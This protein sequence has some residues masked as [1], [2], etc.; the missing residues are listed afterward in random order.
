MDN[1]KEGVETGE[2]G[3]KGWRGGGWGEKAE[4]CT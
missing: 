4:N 3:G 2:G 1:N